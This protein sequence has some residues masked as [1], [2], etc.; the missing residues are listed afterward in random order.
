MADRYQRLVTSSGLLTPG[1]WMATDPRV[2]TAK[3]LV[4]CKQC[5]GVDEIGDDYAIQPDGRVTPRWHCP[6][7]TCGETSW[8][9]LE[10]Y[11]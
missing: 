7:A 10:A 8:L 2:V 9:V 11:E 5:G 3:A 4:C 6:T 1:Q